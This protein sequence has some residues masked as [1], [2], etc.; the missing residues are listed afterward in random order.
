MNNLKINASGCVDPTAEK[1]IKKV[2][3]EKKRHEDLLKHIYYVC[4]LAGYSIENRIIL[5][6][7][8]TK[9]IWR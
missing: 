4:N 8:K 9:R 5:Q 1:A 3:N 6:D 7:K 2:D